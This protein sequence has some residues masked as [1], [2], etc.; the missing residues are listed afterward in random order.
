MTTPIRPPLTPCSR[1]P[2]TKLEK[3][4]ESAINGMLATKQA[5]LNTIIFLRPS[6]SASRPAKRVEMTLPSKTAATTNDN[7]PALNPEVASMYGSAPA[8]IPTS[9]P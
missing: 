4:C 5:P 7:C 9:M 1:R 6:Q 2:N 3:L 8:M